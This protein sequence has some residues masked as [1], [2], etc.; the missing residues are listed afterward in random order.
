MSFNNDLDIKHNTDIDE[1]G[2]Y[3]ESILEVR[4]TD[5]CFYV[6]IV[7]QGSSSNG[8]FSVLN[9]ESINDFEKVKLSDIFVT[10]TNITPILN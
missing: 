5:V 7:L 2:E 6:G 10:L 1:E 4:L 9:D 8:L 3:F